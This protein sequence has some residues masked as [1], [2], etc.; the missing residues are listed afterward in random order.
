[1]RF[2]LPRLRLRWEGFR[3]V[4]RQVCRRIGRRMRELGLTSAAAYRARLEADADEW[5]RLDA[6]CRISISR[7]FRDR[8]V[9]ES[10]EAI[11]LPALAERARA[12]GRATLRA[13]CA[14]CASGEEVFSLAALWAGA[15]ALRSPGLRLEILGTDADP[16]L[17]ARA[18]RAVFRESSLREVP[19]ALRA[20][21]FERRERGYVVRE[22]LRE[23]VELLRQDL[24]EEMPEGPFELILC[25]NAAFTY[26]ETALQREILARLHR[27]L[28]PGGALVIG[29]H[30]SLPAPHPGLEPWPGCRAVYQRVP[31]EAPG[32]G[33]AS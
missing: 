1:M 6:M 30:E 15:L 26:F 16:A 17:L 23:D 8:G 28:R 13:W 9:F 7:C 22:T 25:R 3:R 32:D 20:F 14:G 24:R 12:A 27:R 21:A 19:E 2:A 10:L 18:Q 11:V 5:Q 4:R 29:L 31:P 33:P